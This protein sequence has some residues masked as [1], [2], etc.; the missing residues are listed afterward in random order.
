MM[1]ITSVA[2]AIL[3]VC[4]GA[5]QAQPNLTHAWGQAQDFL[6]RRPSADFPAPV[7]V[8][9]RAVV[10][11]EAE[12]TR[13]AEAA[14]A[15]QRA[16]EPLRAALLELE[17][18]RRPQADLLA[19]LS[20]RAAEQARLADELNDAVAG[21]LARLSPPLRANPAAKALM[22]RLDVSF[23]AFYGIARLPD[24][25]M[26]GGK[27]HPLAKYTGYLPDRVEIIADQLLET[28]TDA[29]VRATL[30][31]VRAKA[32]AYNKAMHR[33]NGPIHKLGHLVNPHGHH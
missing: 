32:Q 6:L 21:L 16:H 20:E 10:D 13:L 2:A 22:K 17:R 33:M 26:L 28:E 27:P 8:A 31:D 12:L 18:V 30:E 5:T 14:E 3:L 25:P 29:A 11:L 4:S 19:T 24:V 23:H 9:A 7:A 1:K 15:Q